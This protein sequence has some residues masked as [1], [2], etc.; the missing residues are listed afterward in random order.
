[1]EGCKQTRVR[2]KSVNWE[3][4]MYEVNQFTKSYLKKQIS[5]S[6]S[7]STRME[8]EGSASY[9]IDTA[10]QGFYILDYNFFMQQQILPVNFCKG[11]SIQK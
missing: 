7:I 2:S 9:P 11:F 4:K 3:K 8:D 5:L 6:I 1:M 10:F